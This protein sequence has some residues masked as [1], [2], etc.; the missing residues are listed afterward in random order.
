MR[1][2]SFIVTI[3]GP[4]A[5]GK[6]TVS[7]LVAE[8]F[9]WA[10][11]STGAFYRGLALVAARENVSLD[12]ETALANLCV[13]TIWAVQM[14]AEQTLVI[15]RGKDVTSEIYSEENGSA[16]SFISRYPK[17]RQNLLAAQRRCAAGTIGLV[18]EGRDCGT[19]V[20]P[21]AQVKIFMTAESQHR[22]ERRAKEQGKNIEETRM[23]QII[24]DLQ[25]SSRT[26]APMQVPK[27][28]HVIDN[29]RISLGEVVVQ[30]E[31]II[32]KELENKS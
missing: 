16:A 27:D 30:V 26:A 2:A 32:R 18:A 10:W 13:S 3:D 5:S 8:Q 19:V 22:A 17:V 14:T 6:T 4:A 9:G 31:Q 1:S 24:R 12:D 21:H 25:D 15:L 7:R 11:V 28:A 23:A 20:F 29:S